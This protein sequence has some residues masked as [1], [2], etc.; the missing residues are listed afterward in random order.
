[1]C[2]TF[3]TGLHGSF[4]EFMVMQRA[5]IC[6]K[7]WWQFIRTVLIS[8]LFLHVCGA[9]DNWGI[10]CKLFNMQIN[11]L[12]DKKEFFVSG[13]ALQRHRTNSDIFWQ[14]AYDTNW[15]CSF[16]DMDSFENTYYI[17]SRPLYWWNTSK[18]CSMAKNSWMHTDSEEILG[19][20]LTSLP[21]LQ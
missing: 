2:W 16:K 3:S 20:H 12:W 11:L 21:N 17:S 8:T 15:L 10:S 4:C 5:I 13:E 14:K 9:L 7:D 6:M 18:I 1:M 19:V